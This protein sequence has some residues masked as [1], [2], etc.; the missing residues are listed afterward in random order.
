MVLSLFLFPNK[1]RFC[2]HPRPAALAPQPPFLNGGA[3][4]W[5]KRGLSV[6]KLFWS[7][8]LCQR[9]ACG[10]LDTW[11]AAL[12]ASSASV[13]RCPASHLHNNPAK[14]TQQPKQQLWLLPILFVF[15]LNLFIYLCI[16]GLLLQYWNIVLSIHDFINLYPKIKVLDNSLLKLAFWTDFQKKVLTCT[17]FFFWGGGFIYLFF[18]KVVTK[19]WH[20]LKEK[21]LLTYCRSPSKS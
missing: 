14:Q 21:N 13:W 3:R 8:L 17:I 15:F 18:T 9:A 10:F 7:H 19:K 2:S 20:R 6:F 11:T 16:W 1:W 12:T 5:S 4:S